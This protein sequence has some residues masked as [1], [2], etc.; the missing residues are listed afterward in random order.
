[1]PEDTKYYILANG[2]GTRWKNYKGVP[3]QLIEIDGETIL[4]RMIRLLHNN[5]VKK[6]NIFI[7]GPFEDEGAMSIITK[8]PTK[9]EVFEEIANLAQGPFVILYGDCY[10]TDICIY[11][12]VHEP[13]KKYDEFFTTSSNPY[14]GCPW[15]EG[16]AHRCEDWEWWRD[17]LHELN[18]NSEIIKAPKDWFLHWW[19]LGVKDERMNGFPVQCYDPDHDIHWLDETDDFDFPIDLDRFCKLTG[20]KCTN[21]EAD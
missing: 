3:K 14:T 1:M 2:E 6:E 18:S 4:H 9:R 5:D 11:R 12:V 7:C 20:H 10:Y 8:S 16:Y 15:A 19:L 13:V 17:E 21:K